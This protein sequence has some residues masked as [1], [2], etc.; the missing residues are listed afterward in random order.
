MFEY[1][2]FQITIWLLMPF[3]ESAELVS[4]TQLRVRLYGRLAADV[5]TF[6]YSNII[7]GGSRAWY[8]ADK[9]PTK[10][11]ILSMFNPYGLMWR[12]VRYAAHLH[13]MGLVALGDLA[14]RLDCFFVCLL[15]EPDQRAT[16]AD[17]VRRIGSKV[18]CI[19]CRVKLKMITC[20]DKF[21]RFG[22]I[23]LFSFIG[24]TK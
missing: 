24:T 8:T 11:I 6:P 1:W 16:R 12:I 7:T 5:P 3:G 20:F 19:R 2:H 15:Y 9:P 10:R 23:F 17:N 13:G 4:F 22:L 14:A 21:Y 18:K